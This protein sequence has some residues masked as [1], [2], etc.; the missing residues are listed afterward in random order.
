MFWVICC[1]VVAYVVVNL[2]LLYSL[3]LV[4]GPSGIG[5]LWGYSPQQFFFVACVSPFAVFATF[6]S[7]YVLM[8]R[9]APKIPDEYGGK[10]FYENWIV[11]LLLILMLASAITCVSYYKT[12]M[13]F[14][15]LHPALASHAVAAFQAV[16][17]EVNRASLAVRD[18]KRDEIISGATEEKKQAESDLLQLH[19]ASA[20][21]AKLM[22]LPPAV[23]LQVVQ[24]PS[25]QLRLP[26]LNPTIRALNML[27]LL[28]G[29]F[30][31]ICAM[32]CV[33]L[34]THSADHLT[35]KALHNSLHSA[36]TTLFWAIAFFGVFAVCYQQYR[37]QLQA[38][39]GPGSTI[40]P[41]WFVGI[42]VLILL[43]RLTVVGAPEHQFDVAG[44]VWRVLPMLAFVSTV[45]AE[46]YRPDVMRTILGCQTNWGTQAL[47]AM[48]F[49][50]VGLYSV[51]TRWPSAPK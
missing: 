12:P 34:A 23:F 4:E 49:G 48:S 5:K 11:V 21:N 1:T 25:L 47:L 17:A 31:A 41:Q 6:T 29:L 44:I 40:Q 51:L 32:F 33:A 45:V 15:K 19:T 3:F 7:L 35:D 36:M 13:S 38:V 14:D 22:A 20:V 24:D 28:V 30:I 16:E 46:S 2:P 39:M 8:S 18:D 37:L 10:W 43:V 26:I 42:F 50:L 9:V 27:Q